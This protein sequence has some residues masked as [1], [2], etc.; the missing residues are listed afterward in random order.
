MILNR[1][2]VKSCRAN[3]AAG[4]VT[5]ALALH[6]GAQILVERAKLGEWQ[7]R[8]TVLNLELTPW[9]GEQLPL[10]EEKSPAAGMVEVPEW[11]WDAL[12]AW[13]RGVL[14]V[15]EVACRLLPGVLD[16]DPER[17]QACCAQ[18]TAW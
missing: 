5:L 9:D 1:I 13:V 14:P 15:L 16:D 11:R 6:F 7:D 3:L 10:L 12:L 17:L 2:T 8:E 4:E 18:R